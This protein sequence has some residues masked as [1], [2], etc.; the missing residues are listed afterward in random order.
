MLTRIAWPGYA[1]RSAPHRV[2]GGNF[3]DYKAM[4]DAAY[5]ACNNTCG[6]P[7][8]ISSMGTRQGAVI[9]RE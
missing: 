4:V 3:D 9:T 2:S 8:R 6:N 5:E 1:H 7:A